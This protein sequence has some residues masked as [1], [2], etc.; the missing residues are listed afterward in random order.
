MKNLPDI[1]PLKRYGTR[2][3]LVGGLYA[4]ALAAL[5]L[6]ALILL[7]LVIRAV[8]TQY[9]ALD[10]SS[11]A[12]FTLSDTTIELLHTLP[13]DVTAYYLAQSGQEDT[14]IT[15]LLDRYAG[16][17]THFSWQQ[18]DPVLYP[19]FAEKYDGAT[20]GCVILTSGE[21]YQVVSYSNMYD[22][23]LEAYYTSGSQEYTFEAE[24]ALTSALSKVIRTTYYLL[25]EVTGHGET[26]LGDDFVETLENQGVSVEALNLTATGSVPG[27][28]DSVLI[29]APLTDFSTEETAVLGS[30][31]QTG[32]SVLFDTD[33][34]VDTPVLDELL[35]QIGMSRQ[36]GLLVETDTDHYPYGYPQTYLLPN[37]YSNQIT[38]G[39]GSNMMVYTPIAQGILYDETGDYEYTPLLA[40]SAA[41]FSMAD[42]AIAET[43]QK[44]DT[45]PEG[46]FYVAVAAE[47]H[48][49]DAKI[50]WINCPNT[51]LS[52]IDQSVSGG[53]SKL[54]GSIVNWMN[55]E[56]TT[57]VIDGKSMSAETLTIP[58]TVTILL[59]VFFTLVLPVVCLVVGAV[60]C[61]VRRRK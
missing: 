10:I 21:K 5:T 4:A 27:D 45:D 25:Y 3:T 42:Y 29:N 59:G 39:V 6:L 52:A 50:V 2:R 38:A 15:R 19:T 48:V 23:N 37:V 26:S 11:G 49:T 24:N 56:Q 47:N 44:A 1:L 60:I 41:A 32:G 57:A 46:T 22:M 30:Y 40:T 16:E 9:T 13:A 61:L 53:N 36:T 18:R 12:M 14:N 43:A 28:A 35:S 58:N 51:L 7:N 55:G 8:P 20:T 31:L 33:F 34:T 54:L 17:S